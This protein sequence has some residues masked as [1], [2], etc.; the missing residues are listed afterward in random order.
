[1][2]ST[3]PSKKL[4]RPPRTPNDMAVF[5]AD[6]QRAMSELD[7]GVGE[8]FL[9]SAAASGKLNDSSEIPGGADANELGPFSSESETSR[10]AALLNYPR[11]GTQRW[12]VLTAI[13][14]SGGRTRDQLSE[15][16]HLPDSSVDA[17]VWELKK[18]GWIEES[19]RK[20]RTR[21]AA[22]AT[23]LV[24]TTH[25]REEVERSEGFVTGRLL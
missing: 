17:R 12:K 10:G 21:A 13:V 4:R 22:E 7:I 8:E 3:L 1:M 14:S 9:I 24:A 6:F 25:G 19:S 23:V 2:A 18:G 20:E 11:S 15:E 16:L 5:M